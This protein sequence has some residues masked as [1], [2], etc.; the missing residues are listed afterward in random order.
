M[1]PQEFSHRKSLSR[2][3]GGR[4]ALILP[5]NRRTVVTP[6]GAVRIADDFSSL[7]AL[8]PATA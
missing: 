8:G 4:N 7:T 1:K 6:Y 3:D 2:G 5:V